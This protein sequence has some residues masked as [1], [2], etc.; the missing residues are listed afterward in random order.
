MSPR[1]PCSCI[2]FDWMV[3]VLPFLERMTEYALGAV[4]GKQGKVGFFNF[5]LNITPDCDCLPW[6]DAPI[7]PDIGILASRTQWP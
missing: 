3:Q 4:K 2:D 5:L 1:L 7:V 6:S